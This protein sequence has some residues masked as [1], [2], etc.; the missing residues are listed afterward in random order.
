MNKRTTVGGLM[1][2]A[3]I[4]LGAGLS[5]VT[6]GGSTWGLGV[7][8]GVYTIFLL[9]YW[10]KKESAASWIPFLGLLLLIALGKASLLLLLLLGATIGS[11]VG[12]IGFILCEA[13]FPSLR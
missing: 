2:S 12:I 6:V 9:F 4:G 8:L 13:I 10:L 1:V 11:F 3:P 5:V 7:T